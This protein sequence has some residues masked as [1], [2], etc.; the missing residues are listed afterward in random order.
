MK[1]QFSNKPFISP[2]VGLKIYR[3]SQCAMKTVNTETFLDQECLPT[4]FSKIMNQY[5]EQG[6]MFKSPFNDSNK[7]FTTKS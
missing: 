4:K 2:Q 3:C 6:K 1:H 7:N 5:H